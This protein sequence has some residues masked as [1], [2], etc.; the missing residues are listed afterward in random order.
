MGGE[1][2]EGLAHALEP[3]CEQRA[4]AAEVET[5]EALPPAPECRTVIEGHPACLEEEGERLVVRDARLA[6]VEPGEIGA[7]GHPYLDPR[8]VGPHVLHEKVPVVLEVAQELV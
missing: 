1:A 5:H 8:E 3:L 2:A 6:A 7:L 4:R